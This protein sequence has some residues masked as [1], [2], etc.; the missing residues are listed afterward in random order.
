MADAESVVGATADYLP[1]NISRSHNW[2][3]FE[4]RMYH[5]ID[6]NVFDFEDDM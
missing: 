5:M 2:V 3:R 4:E 1:D 6:T